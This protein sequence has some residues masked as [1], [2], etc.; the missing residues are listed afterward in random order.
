MVTIG[1]NILENLTTGMYSDSKVTYRE[2]IQ[3][4]CDQIDKA[5]EQNVISSE[6]ALIDIYIDEGRRYISIKDNATG[7][8][9]DDFSNKLGDIANS[10]KE[11]GKDKGF[12]G[13]G[14]LCGLAYCK[15]LKFTASAI[16]EDKASI[17]ICDAE[18]MRNM[19]RDNKK[20]TIEEI[21][22]EIIKFDSKDEDINEHYFEVELFEI[23]KE[24]TDLLDEK[25]V[26]E[27]L[28]FVAPVPYKNTF[29]FS[30]QI[31]DH[32]A[33][34]GYN[35]DEYTI[36]VNGEQVFKEYTT[37]LKDKSGNNLKNY[38]EIFRLEFKDFVEKDGNLVAWM[39]VGI[40]TFERQIPEVNAMRG[41]RLRQ[42]NIQI[43]DKEVF[44]NFFKEPRGYLYFVGE[45]FS[46]NRELIANSQRDYFNENETR[47]TLENMLRVYFYDVLTR[48]YTKSN[49]IKN[50]YKKHVELLDK[51]TE[52]E[53]K[54]KNN[55]FVDK[56]EKQK[57]EFAIKEAKSKVDQAEK[58]L[59][60]FS[61]SSVISSEAKAILLDVKE[62]IGV[63]Y[64]SSKIID[65][66]EKTDITQVIKPKTTHK[67]GVGYA[68]EALS[69]LDKKERK[70]VS[71]IWSIITNNAPKE[72]A[73]DLIEKIK[74]EFK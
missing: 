55:N 46:V 32:A 74:E 66:V 17:M 49:D 59:N 38:D 72:V 29:L 58:T 2:Y 60:N 12:R 14:R 20:Y 56:D 47:V 27:Y 63:K 71:K 70:L 34:I 67:K 68:V 73:E 1:K 35:I 43:G 26:K 44:K 41:L 31:Y 36:K 22:G 21:L 11:Q 42:A 57:L 3:N 13:I 64:N 19:L 8:P 10:D 62:K 28:S 69:K 25:M 7:I 45:I 50:A 61:N 53:D 23:N 15:I 54:S 37:K 6:D 5:I 30:G 48:L 40:S 24:N 18:K 39:W 9:A 51:I 65:Q 33:E 52:F 16:G 4:A